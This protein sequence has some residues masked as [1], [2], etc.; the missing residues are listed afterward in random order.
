MRRGRLAGAQEAARPLLQQAVGIRMPGLH[1][2]ARGREQSSAS[3]TIGSDRALSSR[4]MPAGC[5]RRCSTRMLLSKTSVEAR[6]ENRAAATR[7]PSASSL[8][9]RLVGSG[10]M[11]RVWSRRCWSCPSRGH[12]H[13]PMLAEGDR[14]PVAVGGQMADAVDRHVGLAGLTGGRFAGHMSGF[15]RATPTTRGFVPSLAEQE[16]RHQGYGRENG[17]S[18]EQ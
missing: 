7:L 16:A 9:R 11:V 4:L 3:R 6:T 8:K 17:R 12:E 1:V 10:V 14:T 18:P 2:T 5:E 15:R 13:H